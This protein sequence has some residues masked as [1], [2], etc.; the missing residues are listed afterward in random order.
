MKVIEPLFLNDLYEELDKSKK[1]VT[2]LKKL[3]KRISEIKIFD[4]ACGSG[5]FLIIAY[6]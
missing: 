5:N 1:S 2:K 3:L 6:K 4:P